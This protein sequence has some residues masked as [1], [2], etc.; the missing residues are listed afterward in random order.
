MQ[1]VVL[2]GGY[3]GARMAHGFALLDDVDLTVIGN[4]A[5]DLELHALY[6]SPDLDTVMYTLA[7]LA[8]P[9]TGWGVREETWSASEMLERYGAETWFR[10]GDRDL[11]THVRRSALLRDGLSLTE[12][13]RRLCAALGVAT[14]LLPMSDEPVR[15]KLRTA[16]GWL[17][18]QDYFVRRGHRDEVLELRFEGADSARPTAEVLAAIERAELI[19]LAPSNPFVSIGPMLAL[20]GLRDALLAAAAPVVAVSPIVGGSAVRG[21]AADMLRSL[22]TG[23]G[24]AGVA[25]FY[26]EHHPGLI[27]VLVIDEADRRDEA[28]I[29]T[30][31]S[32]AHVTRTLMRDETD[33]RRLANEILALAREPV[34][35]T[36][37]R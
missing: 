31:G 20:G 13:T 18:F 29:S 17:E 30:S 5:D 19:V 23:H 3:G 35:E 28:A 22:G 16:E 27:D 12:V 25:R 9:E 14:R 21:P 33:R 10:L 6:V 7:G 32:V 11:A 1:I 24:S 8:N 26:G 2:A 34:P 37:R 36:A 15:T 4:T